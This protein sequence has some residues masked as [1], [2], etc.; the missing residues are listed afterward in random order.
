[1]SIRNCFADDY[2]NDYDYNND[3]GACPS[4]HLLQRCSPM[5]NSKIF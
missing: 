2:D 1:M 4:W 3:Y 5:T